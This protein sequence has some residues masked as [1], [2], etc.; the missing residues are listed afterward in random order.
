[1]GVLQE[2]RTGERIPL[3]PLHRVGRAVDCALVLDHPWVSRDHAALCWTGEGWE[4]R[5]AGSH[6][7]TRLD[8]ERLPSGARRRLSPGARLAFGEETAS[9]LLLDASPPQPFALGPAGE[10]V[11]GAG[12]LLELP[13][14]G[15]Q[16]PLVV[17]R[18]R[19]GAW[20]VE[21]EEERPLEDNAPLWLDG[22]ELRLRL[23]ALAALT[24]GR[25]EA[26]A[27]ARFHV[28]LDEEEVRLVVL[29]GRVEADLGARSHHYLLLTL[30]RQ[31]LADAARPGLPPEE[32]GWLDVER[33]AAGL[34]LEPRYLNVLVHRARRQAVE[35]GLACAHR[36][37][38]R[39]D[40][41]RQIRFGLAGVQV[42]R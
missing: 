42:Q 16:E 13:R 17:L 31:R 35:A 33:L 7:G 12:G 18:G 37:I 25:E 41:A 4:L 39:R 10:R 34:R 2:L 29:E 26:E 32:H 11:L 14:P 40:Q 30:A 1:M 6:N 15:G 20:V 28:S 5:D 19:G 3:L 24:L 27:R 23:P 9:H 8:G 36:L 21:G 22:R 38:E